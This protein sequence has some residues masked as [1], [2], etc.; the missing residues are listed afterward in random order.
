M[1][2]AAIRER[3]F[4][5]AIDKITKSL[6]D[7]RAKLPADVAPSTSGNTTFRFRNAL[8]ARRVALAGSFNDWNPTKTFFT[9]EGDEWVCRIDLPPGKYDYKLVVDG[10]YY[11]DPSNANVE[12]D[13]KGHV[14]YPR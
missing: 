2:S 11:V 13:G 3:A 4:D 9:R 7:A 10:R 14:N 8:Y 12:D 5:E 1:F 6:D